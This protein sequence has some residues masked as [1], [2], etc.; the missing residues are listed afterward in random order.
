MPMKLPYSLFAYSYISKRSYIIKSVSSQGCRIVQHMQIII[1]G[2]KIFARYT[3][4]K[5]LIPVYTGNSKTK[6]PKKQ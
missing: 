3:S 4:D 5:G 6:L 1:F 2:R